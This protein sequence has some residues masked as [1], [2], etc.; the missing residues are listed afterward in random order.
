ME[1]T[2]ISVVGNANVAHRCFAKG[3][4]FDGHGERLHAVGT[5]DEATVAVGLLHVM[6]MRLNHYLLRSI[7]AC[8]VA[9]GGEVC[10]GEKGCHWSTG[11]GL[12]VEGACRF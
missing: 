1:V 5:C 9:N 11:E 7:E 6:L 2:P 12:E 10:G 3:R 8:V 4:F